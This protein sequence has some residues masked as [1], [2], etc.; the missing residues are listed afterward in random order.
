[1]H[2]IIN[3]KSGIE[4]NNLWRLSLLV[5]KFDLSSKVLRVN[6][7]SALFQILFESANA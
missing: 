6:Q 3:S 7:F 4:R 1:M 2:L 5:V